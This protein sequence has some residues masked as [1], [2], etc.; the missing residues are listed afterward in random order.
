MNL[1]NVP[2]L[3]TE[4]QLS[5]I[6]GINIHRDTMREFID[7]ANQHTYELI[8]REEML[9][10]YEGL[11]TPKEVAV[12]F[13]RPYVERGDTYKE[14]ATGCM[15]S[16]DAQIGGYY[17]EHPN[18]ALHKLKAGEIMARSNGETE[19]FQLLTLYTGILTGE[20]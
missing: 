1:F 19:V 6:S 7:A 12:E 4:K 11:K 15:G 13:I 2:T 5:L 3:L 14:L 9:K 20:L 16:H 18:E 17:A 10:K 8:K